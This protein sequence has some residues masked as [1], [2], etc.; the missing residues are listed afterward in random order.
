MAKL[1][2]IGFSSYSVGDNLMAEADSESRV[3][4]D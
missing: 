1:W 2:L 4:V 3:L